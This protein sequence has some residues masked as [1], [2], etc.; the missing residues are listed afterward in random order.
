MATVPSFPF[1]LSHHQVNI[2]MLQHVHSSDDSL[3][4]DLAPMA[5]LDLLLR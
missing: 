4:G 2:A 3:S 5:A 1:C